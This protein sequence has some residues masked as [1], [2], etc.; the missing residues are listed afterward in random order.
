MVNCMLLLADWEV[1]KVP[2][3]KWNFGYVSPGTVEHKSVELV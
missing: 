3:R 2:P 1:L